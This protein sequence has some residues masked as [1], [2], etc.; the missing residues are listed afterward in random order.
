MIPS[1]VMNDNTMSFLI[2][3][4]TPFHF[5]FVSSN[6]LGDLYPERS[7]SHFPN[8]RKYRFIAKLNFVTYLS[9]LTQS[10]YNG[11][12]HESKVFIYL[13]PDGVPDPLSSNGGQHCQIRG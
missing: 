7:D 10:M 2:L 4:S 5:F 1:S 13:M 9:F 6:H 12:K 8:Q 11:T 3:P